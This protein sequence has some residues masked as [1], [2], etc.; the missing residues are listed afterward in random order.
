M[1]DNQLHKIIKTIPYRFILNYFRG[2]Q[3]LFRHYQNEFIA[4]YGR[5]ISGVVVELG[6]E[7]KYDHQRFFPAAERFVCTNIA[8]EYD[9]YL[10][11]VDMQYADESVDNY[12]CV[13][14]LPHLFDIHQA[15]SEI[16]RTLKPG[17]KLLLV[18]PFAF[19]V[20]DDRDFWRLSP[21]SYSRFLKGYNIDEY[22]HLGGALSVAAEVLKRPKGVINLRYFLYKCV[23][24]IALIMAKYLDRVD[25][26]P[27]GYGIVATKR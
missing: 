22:V 20:C 18:V 12:L 2:R 26:I 17:G 7:K 3:S 8:R 21:S 10:N 23:G 25:S 27:I 15:F 9:E 13:S 19:P 24:F 14:V 1:W 5:E 16:Y 11:I 4:R 6:G